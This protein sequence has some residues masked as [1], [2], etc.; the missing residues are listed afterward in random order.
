MTALSK[1]FIE[2]DD[3]YSIHCFAESLRAESDPP[4]G[5]PPELAVPT[6][7]APDMLGGNEPHITFSQEV[8]CDVQ[9]GESCSSRRII[10][11]YCSRCPLYDYVP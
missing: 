4:S 5:T 1:T 11:C 9:N 8:Q 6:Q 3:N 7:T 10:G 2:V